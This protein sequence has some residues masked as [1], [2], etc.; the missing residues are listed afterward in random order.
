MW[1]VLVTP[2]DL[3]VLEVLRLLYDLKEKLTRQP[4]ERAA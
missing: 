4:P 3:E 2:L 1:G